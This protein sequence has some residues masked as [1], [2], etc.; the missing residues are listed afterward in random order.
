MGQN[1]QILADENRFLTAEY[2]I[3]DSAD[4]VKKY[5]AV[6]NTDIQVHKSSPGK[7]E[8]DLARLED[9]LRERS[10]PITSSSSNTGPA[11]S[12]R[13]NLHEDT[14]TE[15]QKAEY[16]GLFSTSTKSKAGSE[17]KPEN[18]SQ[19]LQEATKTTTSK[20][21]GT[22]REPPDIFRSFSQPNAKSDPGGTQGFVQTAYEVENL[23]LVRNEEISELS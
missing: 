19:S 17:S 21:H 3:D 6:Q 8:A 23:Q 20:L 10:T 15:S 4:W 2:L 9:F 22:K 13:Y 1:L 12:L 11:K 14:K 16:P 7:E 5:G 18:K